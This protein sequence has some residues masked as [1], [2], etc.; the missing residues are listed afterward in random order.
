MTE[1]SFVG[2]DNSPPRRIDKLKQTDM[3]RELEAFVRQCIEAVRNGSRSNCDAVVESIVAEGRRDVHEILL[4]GIRIDRSGILLPTRP[5]IVHPYSQNKVDCFLWRLVLLADGRMDLDPSLEKSS[6]TR[7]SFQNHESTVYDT[8]RAVGYEAFVLPDEMRHLP[9]LRRLKLPCVGLKAFP[10]P[11]LGMR[12]L[13]YLD[14]S[15]NLFLSNIPNAFYGLA[16]LKYLDLSHCEIRSISHLIANMLELRVLKLASTRIRRLPEEFFRLEKLVRLDLGQIEMCDFNC[17]RGGL[18]G[19]RR[20][21]LHHVSIDSTKKLRLPEGLTY[22][23]ISASCWESL[24]TQV[25]E[26]SHLRYLVMKHNLLLEIP[27]SIGS[28]TRLRRLDLYSS[29]MFRIS[30]EILTLKELRFVR[31]NPYLGRACVHVPEIHGTGIDGLRRLVAD[32]QLVFGMT[33]TGDPTVDKLNPY[34][35]FRKWRRY[36]YL[37]SQVNFLRF[38]YRR[39]LFE[40]APRMKS[41]LDEGATWDRVAKG[42]EI[43]LAKRLDHFITALLYPYRILDGVLFRMPGVWRPF[44]VKGSILHAAALALIGRMDEEELQA[45]LGEGRVRRIFDKVHG[46]Y[47]FMGDFPHLEE[48]SVECASGKV[49]EEIWR[50]PSLKGIDVYGA[51]QSEVERLADM[52]HLERLGVFQS[53]FPD[54]FCLR[55]HPSMREITMEIETGNPHLLFLDMEALESLRLNLDEGMRNIVV[56]SCPRLS[57]LVVREAPNAELFIVGCPSIRELQMMNV[58]HADLERIVGD[59]PQL[60][61]IHLIG[62]GIRI[63]PESIASLERIKSLIFTGCSIERIPDFIS[64]L[65]SLRRLEVFNDNSFTDYEEDPEDLQVIR[66]VPLSLLRKSGLQLSLSLPDE[67]HR[68]LLA[69][70]GPF[71]LTRNLGESHP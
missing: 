48:L 52:S 34:F 33:P 7:V 30:P 35:H 19:L 38:Q 16:N 68:R 10:K 8:R 29:R 67:L 57:S 69:H 70:P 66:H 39:R 53:H 60:E 71:G 14:L 5:F 54:T 13:E 2:N 55:G 41:Y 28:L 62:V 42:V 12:N 26:L 63:I 49:P 27:D 51:S 3:D 23:N 43:I 6:I 20:L 37:E 47:G 65:S 40:S 22:L 45:R 11:V 36:M 46:V 15:G 50:L 25:T 4:K 17:H 32:N 18:P 24:P 61:S 9:N 31:L 1:D 58:G 64:Q 56:G 44:Q 59:N 21:D